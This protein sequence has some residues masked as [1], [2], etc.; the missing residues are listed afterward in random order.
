[1]AKKFGKV[2]LFTAAVGSAAAAV[3]YFLRK[4][5]NAQDAG[6]EEDYDDFSDDLEDSSDSS[7]NYVALNPDTAN[8]EET[9]ETASEEAAPGEEA[10]GEKEAFTP[11]TEQVAQSMDKAE[12][13]VEAF[14][15]EDEEDT[16]EEPPI[17]DN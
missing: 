5:D 8:A 1:M 11:L 10:S 17:S 2:L 12:E 15:D 4:K 6:E 7:R 16:N 14:F 13:S 3:C 9:A